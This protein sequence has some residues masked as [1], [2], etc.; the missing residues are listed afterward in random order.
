MAMEIVLGFVI[1]FGAPILLIGLIF[2]LIC[3]HLSRRHKIGR[4]GCWFWVGF[5]TGPIG[6]GLI[7]IP[8]GIHTRQSEDIMDKIEAD[9][10]R[11]VKKDRPLTV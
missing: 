7:L 1:L 11:N 8:I 6:L 3:N 4:S 5:F 10:I 2:G 9:T